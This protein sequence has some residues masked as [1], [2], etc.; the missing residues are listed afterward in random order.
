ML[1]TQHLETVDSFLL[2]HPNQKRHKFWQ[3]ALSQA[4]KALSATA[5]LLCRLLPC[6]CVAGGK[7]QLAHS[8]HAHVGQ[9]LPPS[10]LITPCDHRSSYHSMRP[11]I[12]AHIVH[13]TA[14]TPYCNCQR[15]ATYLELFLEFEG[16]RIVCCTQAAHTTHLSPYFALRTYPDTYHCPNTNVIVASALPFAFFTTPATLAFGLPLLCP[17]LLMHQ[18]SLVG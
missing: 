5:R 13:V 12:T 6:C 8:C 9:P 4:I 17:S 7:A 3:T 10:H 14:I 11:S 1:S 18:A 2:T 16:F 15:Q